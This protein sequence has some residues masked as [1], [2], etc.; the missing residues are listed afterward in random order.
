M[1]TSRPPDILRELIP[2]EA[3][4]PTPAVEVDEGEDDAWYILPIAHHRIHALDKFTTAAVELVPEYVKDRRD[5]PVA[6]PSQ[7]RKSVV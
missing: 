1:D 6:G 2:I 7:D 4:A 3:P 5:D